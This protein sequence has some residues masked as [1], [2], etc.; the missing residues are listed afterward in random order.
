ML[1]SRSGRPLN[2][3]LITSIAEYSGGYAAVAVDKKG[4]VDKPV[5]SGKLAF[6]FP[7]TPAPVENVNVAPPATKQ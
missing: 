4:V 1:P 6:V 2:H 3:C 5:T 7:I